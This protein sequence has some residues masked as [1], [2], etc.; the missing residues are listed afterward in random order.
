MLRKRKIL[1][2][3]IIVFLL[4]Q[5][6]FAQ[7][8]N[9]EFTFGPDMTVARMG[10]YSVPLENQ[11]VLLIGGHGT[12]FVSLN[13][14]ELFTS[15]PDAFVSQTMNFPHD[16]GG[17]A[18][19]QDGRILIAGG[20]MDLGVAPGYSNAEIYNPSYGNYSVTGSLNFPR[21][22]TSAATLS[23]GNILFVGGWYDVSSGTYPEI[24]SVQNNSFSLTGPLNTSR[25][26]PIVIPTNDGGAMIIGGSP[27]YGGADIKQVEY[28]NPAT[29]TFSVLSDYLF[30]SDDSDWVPLA[31]SYYNRLMR[32]QQTNEG[33]YVLIAYKAESG[34]YFFTLFLVDPDLKT[35]SK[36]TSQSELPDYSTHFLL[37]PVVDKNKN[38]AYIPATK[39]G[40][41]PL[42]IDLIA[43]DLVDGNFLITDTP[44][45][46]PSAYYLS[47]AAYNLLDDGRILI[48]GGHSQTGYNTNF[49][50][51]TKTLFIKP[52]FTPTGINSEI[53]PVSDYKLNFTNYPNPFN[54]ATTF[55]FELNRNE[56]VELDVINIQGE[57]VANLFKKDLAPGTHN[58]NWNANTLASG[59]YL[60]RLKTSSGIQ[61]R[62][63]VLLK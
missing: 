42:Q 3:L 35:I 62:K 2:T 4:L 48:S 59:I 23:N 6:Q 36:I 60:C 26:Q 7:T 55:R 50:P 5:Y 22:M 18:E 43:F 16:F 58:Y 45:T 44:F 30:G 17:V 41:N 52:N 37:A 34:N 10:H 11:S 31:Q 28:F 19:M 54:N 20:A 25:A 61:F 21:M 13:N 49:S 12:S 46:F 29:N 39:T 1:L 15:N 8:F 53:D 56:T 38:V 9:P 40:S 24:Y 27:I 32:T 33:K 51:I 63:V 57:I 14:S 47:S